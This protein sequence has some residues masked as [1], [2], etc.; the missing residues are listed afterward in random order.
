MRWY[1][2]NV[3]GIVAFRAG[4]KLQCTGRDSMGRVFRGIIRWREWVG[5]GI[6]LIVHVNVV[7][8]LVFG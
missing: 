6:V 5:M 1:G 3:W 4:A 7:V 8:N 2:H